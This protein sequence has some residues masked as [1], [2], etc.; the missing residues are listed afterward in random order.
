MCG[1]ARQKRIPIPT[2]KR[3]HGYRGEKSCRIPTN[4]ESE[5][6]LQAKRQAKYPKYRANMGITRKKRPNT[7]NIA[8]AWVC[9]TEKS[10][11]T[12]SHAITW[13]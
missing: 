9:Q 6:V 7:Q 12:H 3:Q 4:I 11:Y 13:V 10:P 2:E 8:T 1:Y 5:R